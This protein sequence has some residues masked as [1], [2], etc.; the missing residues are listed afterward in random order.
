MYR[1]ANDFVQRLGAPFRLDQLCNE[2]EM[3]RLKLAS[4]TLTTRDVAPQRRLPC[5]EQQI[6]DAIHRRNDDD[7]IRRRPPHMPKRNPNRLGIADSDSAKLEYF[8]TGL[9]HEAPEYT[10]RG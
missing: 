9:L 5:I 8:R 4:R 6:G 10:G 2:R 7:D 3:P 1:V